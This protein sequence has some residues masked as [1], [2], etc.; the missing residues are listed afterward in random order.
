[1]LLLV[2]LLTG[3]AAPGQ[4]RVVV[5][6]A[7]WKAGAASAVITPK[8]M[9]WLA[10]Y[11]AR[12]KPADGV[13]MDLFAKA[14]VL[15]DAAEGPLAIVTVDLV[16]VPREVRLAAAERIH[17][18]HGISPARLLINASHTHS[19]PEMRVWRT[20]N[21]DDSEKREREAKEYCAFLVE[22]FA[23]IV[24]EA[25]SK[26][27]PVDV[28]YTHARCGFSMNRR[29]PTGKG[30]QNAPYSDGPVDQRVPVLRV[31]GKAPKQ[32]LAVL[33]GYAC[34]CT[35]LSG[36]K[37][38]GDYA[39]AAQAFLEAKHPG[40]VALF[41]N[42]CSGDQNPYPRRDPDYVE[43]H[44]R[45]LALAVEAALETPPRP[46]SGPIKSALREIPLRFD[47]LPTRPELETRAKSSDKLDARLATELL[48][49]LD[50]GEALPKDYPYPVQVI[51]L[52]SD[53]TLVAL[54]GE[55]VVDYS[56]RLQRDIN[57]AVVWVAG[58]SNDVMT[59]IPSRRVW[60]EGGY[61]GGDA[62]KWNLFPARWHPDLEEDIVKAVL[63][64]RKD[65]E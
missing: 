7:E 11:A 43:A 36:Q 53:L 47:R 41:M 15:D 46:L 65:L 13:D 58:Y 3:A 25:H 2:A 60:D 62:M 32:E 57:D 18:E 29:R 33:F 49:R 22:T 17:K 31:V 28:D 40:A 20:G 63:D 23:K 19:G 24:G 48:E 8:T 4:D 34:H 10:G 44:G 1:M 16:S 59:Y 30:Y 12:T 26:R 9:M 61:E 38:S 54:G 35:I 37:F 5:T 55:V 6:S 50:A 27:V 51:R 52:G 45:S 21:T 42:G 14:L 56:L 64:V 39:G